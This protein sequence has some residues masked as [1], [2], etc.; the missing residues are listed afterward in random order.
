MPTFDTPATTSSTSGGTSISWSYTLPSYT[1]PIL[2]VS[3]GIYL[4][5]NDIDDITYNSVSCT[6]AVS[7]KIS[8]PSTSCGIYYMLETD[9]PSPASYTV[10]ISTTGSAVAWTAGAYAV[11]DLVQ[12][13]PNTTATDSSFSVTSQSVS[14][15]P[16]AGSIVIDSLYRVIFNDTGGIPD[17]TADGDQDAEVYELDASPWFSDHSASGH[18]SRLN[19]ADGTSESMSWSWTGSVDHNAQA[20]AAFARLSNDRYYR[21][22]QAVINS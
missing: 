3:W 9:L 11:S 1:S 22:T 4:N 2:M 17:P 19:A 15:T 10:Q 14:L 8:G 12:Q 16:P 20:A 6:E 7:M 13:G 5:N 18:A 21:H